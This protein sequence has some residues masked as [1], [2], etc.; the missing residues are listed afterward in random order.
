MEHSDRRALTVVRVLGVAVGLFFVAMAANKLVWLGDSSLLLS[1]FDR[2]LEQATGP[3]HWYLL[4]VA[5][6]GAP[7]FARVVPLAE[8]AAGLALIAGV[9]PRGTSLLA[10]LMVINFHVAT[11]ALFQWDFLR[12]GAG[13]PL[14]GALLAL[15]VGSQ[16]RGHAPEMPRTTVR[17]PNTMGIEARP[18]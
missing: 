18:V 13:P 2:W 11:G 10:L 14:L 16:P 4:H 9:C 1:R 17:G 6:P 5:R 12:D 3:A 15:Y 8:L 7:L